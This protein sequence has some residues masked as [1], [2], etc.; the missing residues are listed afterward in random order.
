M[1]AK[2]AD[3]GLVVVAVTD[4]GRSLVDKFV[5]ETGAKHPILIEKSDSASAYRINGFPSTFLIDADGKIAWAG[6]GA[7]FPESLLTKLLGEVRLLPDLPKSLDGVRKSL[8]KKEFGVARKAL[9]AKAAGAG[10]AAEEKA[11]AETAL[12]WIDDLAAKR[13]ASAEE[14]RKAGDAWAAAETLRRL[15]TEFKGAEAAD[16][17][18]A[19]LDAILAD[20]GL[21]HEVE[22][23]DAWAKLSERLKSLKPEQAIQGCRQ[24]VKKWEGTKAAKKADAEVDRLVKK[25]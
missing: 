4:E 17:A 10:A 23:G 13:L 7:G 25:R 11:A 21:A 15:G 2:F 5:A 14:D 24:F 12:K 20:K 16:K 6:N 19:A 22:A 1:Y 18:K 9:E 8:E 3:K